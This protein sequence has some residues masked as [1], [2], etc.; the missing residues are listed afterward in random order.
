MISYEKLW[1]TMKR[2]GVSQYKLIHEHGFSTGQLDRLRK[3]DNI[4]VYTLNLLCKILDCAIEDIITY[5]PDPEDS[6]K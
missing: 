2:K 1:K 6:T 3:N 4:N 5:I